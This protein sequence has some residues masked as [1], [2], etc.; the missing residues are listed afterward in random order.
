MQEYMLNKTR[1]KELVLSKISQEN[2]VSYE[3][4]RDLNNY[5]VGYVM[6]FIYDCELKNY[7]NQM[8]KIQIYVKIKD[9]DD[10]LPVLSMHESKGE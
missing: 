7:S 1:A 8:R 2:F 10:S 6:I 3:F 9:V 5:G 4:D